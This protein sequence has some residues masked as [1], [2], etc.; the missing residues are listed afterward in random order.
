MPEAYELN[1]LER[2]LREDRRC[3]EAESLGETETCL[4]PPIAY[5]SSRIIIIIIMIIHKLFVSLQKEGI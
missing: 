3:R 5:L 2:T 1:V 4:G